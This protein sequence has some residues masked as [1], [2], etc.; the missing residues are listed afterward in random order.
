MKIQGCF[1]LGLT[2]LITLLFKRL[3][4]VFSVPQFE[5]SVDTTFAKIFRNTLVKVTVYSNGL[6]VQQSALC[7]SWT[8]TF[9]G[10]IEIKTCKKQVR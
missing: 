10:M 4:R 1:L 3:S 9:L 8:V 7:L 6:G 2:G 5:N